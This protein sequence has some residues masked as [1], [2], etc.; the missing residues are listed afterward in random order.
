MNQ[1]ELYW[2][3]ASS[4]KLLEFGE[5]MKRNKVVFGKNESLEHAIKKLT[6]CYELRQ[7]GKEFITE[8]KFFKHEGRAD[9]FVTDDCRAIEIVVSEKPESIE[10]KR[11]KYP[12]KIE[13]I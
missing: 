2:K 1:E 4:L 10:K 7:E 5:R 12:C 8:A 11:R 9:I 6:K 3:R 13:V